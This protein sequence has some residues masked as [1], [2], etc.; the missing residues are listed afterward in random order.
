[1]RAISERFAGAA[2]MRERIDTR[3]RRLRQYADKNLL[4]DE[5]IAGRGRAS[6][7]QFFKITD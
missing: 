7:S 4:K 1:M 2:L 5:S 6:D 3:Q